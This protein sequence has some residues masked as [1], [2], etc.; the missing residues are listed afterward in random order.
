MM[1]D[2]PRLTQTIY[3]VDYEGLGDAWGESDGWIAASGHTPGPNLWEWHLSGAHSNQ[4]PAT[5][6]TQLDRPL[7]TRQTQ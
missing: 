6:T 5:C 7:I 3:H 2:T 4:D 1:I